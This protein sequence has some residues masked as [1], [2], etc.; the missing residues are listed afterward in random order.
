M[1]SVLLLLYIVLLLLYLLY[2]LRICECLG[3][4]LCRTVWMCSACWFS[5]VGNC[6]S[7]FC[8]KLLRCKRAKRGHRRNSDEIDRSH[9]YGDQ[10]FSYRIGRSLSH[11]RKYHRHTHLRKSLRPRSHRAIVRIHRYAHHKTKPS[12]HYTHGGSFGD[13]RVV[14]TT[15]FSRKGATHRQGNYRSHRR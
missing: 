1:A 10:S 7:F 2:K 4:T 8:F 15:K 14:R 11:H 5:I 9:M 6:C 13:I 12:T 3:H